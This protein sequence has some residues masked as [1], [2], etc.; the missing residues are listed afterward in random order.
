M[1]TRTKDI[2]LDPTTVLTVEQTGETMETAKV[3][4]TVRRRPFVFKFPLTDDQV[5]AIADALTDAQIGI[6]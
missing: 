1:R 2:R 5:N 6:L 3:A 4:V